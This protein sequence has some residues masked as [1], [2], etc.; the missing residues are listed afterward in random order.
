MK[1]TCFVLNMKSNGDKAFINKHCMYLVGLRPD[2]SRADII[3]A[4]PSIYIPICQT[5][6]GKYYQ[7]AMQN[8][9]PYDSGDYTGEIS[10]KQIKSNQMNWVIIGHSERKKYFFENEE[11]IG[12]KIERSLE[13]DLKC[14]VCIQENEKGKHEDLVPQ[15]ETIFSQ[16]GNKWGNIVVAYEPTWAGEANVTKEEIQEAHAY[17]RA[18]VAKKAGDDVA[19]KLRIIYGGNVDKTNCADINSQKDVD[20][21]LFGK[22]SNTENLMTIFDTLK[23]KK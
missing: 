13:C 6:I 23:I 11:M 7:V 18:E 2:Q 5:F 21:F 4:P 20:G 14:I 17:I 3:L 10:A 12:K 15:L 1:K 16:V 19:N 8:V 22:I 9:S